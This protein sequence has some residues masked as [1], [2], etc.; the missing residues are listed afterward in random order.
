MK[1]E[2]NELSD[3]QIFEDKVLGKGCLSQV[4]LAQH[5]KTKKRYAVKV[6]SLED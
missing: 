5:R 2:V 3:L 4:Y 6:V 1:E